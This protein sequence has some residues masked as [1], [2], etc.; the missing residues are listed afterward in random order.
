MITDIND[1]L[2]RRLLIDAAL[3]EA[4]NTDYKE[5]VPSDKFKLTLNKSLKAQ[6]MDPVYPF[7]SIKRNKVLVIIAAVFSALAL[8]MSVGAIREKVVNF[9]VEM[10]DTFA[11]ITTNKD[12]DYPDRIKECYAPTY[13]PEGFTVISTH[14]EYRYAYTKMCNDKGDEINIQQFVKGGTYN[15]DA[16]KHVETVS[17]FGVNDG[18]LW[19]SQGIRSLYFEYD[20]YFF[21]IYSRPEISDDELI[22]MAKSIEK[23]EFTKS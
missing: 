1:K 6:G 20:G 17:V 11:V 13:I 19:E 10:F 2:L 4:E 21:I 15:I 16:E 18:I 5:Y 7:I 23:T 22:K 9:F 3:E 12:A 8:S 14:A